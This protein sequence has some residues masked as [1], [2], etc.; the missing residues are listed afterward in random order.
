M[1]AVR[2]VIYEVIIGRGVKALP[3]SYSL[4]HELGRYGTIN[5]AAYGANDTAFGPANI[6]DTGNLFADELFL[7]IEKMRYTQI[8]CNER[9]C[10]PW[11][12]Y[13]CTRKY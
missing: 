13:S 2:R 6:S 10:A 3:V 7:G 5:A 8:G 1:E 4:V 12:S 9:W 11:S